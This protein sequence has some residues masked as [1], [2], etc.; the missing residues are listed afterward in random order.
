MSLLDHGE[1]K[2][3]NAGLLASS[4]SRGWRGV[5]AELRSHPAGSLPAITPT[6]IEIT[7][8]MRRCPGAYVN[9][10]GG[11][12]RQ[13][14]FVDAGTIWLCPAGLGEDDIHI[15]APLRDI[16]HIYL[17]A[18]RFGELSDTCGGGSFQA[19]NL[20][21]LADIHDPLIRAVGL[22]VHS[23]L[24]C[25]SSTGRMMIEAAALALTARL[26]HAYSHSQPARPSLPAVADCPERIRRVMDFVRDNIEQ[27]LS[28]GELAQVACLSPFHF[29]RMFKRVTGQ[30]PHGFVSS[31]RLKQARTLLAASELP[32]VEVALRSGFSTQAAFGEAFKRAVG[33]SPG[34][35]RRRFA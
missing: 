31:E 28:L 35:Y 10:A 2:F 4:R 33:C 26:A 1:R 20:R 25:E 9:R 27:D 11:G 15:S 24:T 8:A 3:P 29:A 22:S 12:A 6:Q 13:R 16:L 19:E 18:D 30:T 23:E 34:A 32:L 17:P 5:A 7:L 14:T 21:Y